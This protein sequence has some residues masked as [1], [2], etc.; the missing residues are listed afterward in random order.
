MALRS[1][2]RAFTLIELMVVIAII[3]MLAAVLLVG[4]SW[5]LGSSKESETTANIKAI[6]GAMSRYELKKGRYPD[7]DLALL[8]N[9]QMAP[10]NGENNGIES[11]A[12]AL[13]GTLDGGPFL[14]DDAFSNM[15]DNLDGD[16]NPDT[17]FLN[18]KDGNGLFELIDPWGNP[19]VYV[20]ADELAEGSMYPSAGGIITL[21]TIEGTVELDL[22][23]MRQTL[24]TEAR[25]KRY[26][27][28]SMGPDGENNYGEGDDIA[29]WK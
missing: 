27:L 14:Q 8:S 23:V 26:Y 1:T 6:E 19:Y 10:P 28:W 2:H 5:A 12:L 4:I 15:R 22:T 25:G 17:S 11:L 24:G 9:N 20:H 3:G 16:T 29:S 21:R 7:S 13:R 18:V